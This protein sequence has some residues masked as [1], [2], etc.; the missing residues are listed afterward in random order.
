MNSGVE[1]SPSIMASLPALLASNIKTSSR[2]RDEGTPTST[3]S[4]SSPLQSPSPCAHPAT[5]ALESSPKEDGFILPPP[6]YPNPL[7][8]NTFS[9]TSNPVKIATYPKAPSPDHALASSHKESYRESGGTPT[10]P[11]ES[12]LKYGRRPGHLNSVTSPLALFPIGSNKRTDSFGAP[13][14]SVPGSPAFAPL[15]NVSESSAPQAI[16]S[17]DRRLSMVYGKHSPL[18]LA[19]NVP[20]VSSASVDFHNAS[21][22]PRETSNQLTSS[23]ALKSAQRSAVYGSEERRKSFPAQ[24][25]PGLRPKL[26]TSAT[27]TQA[28]KS[29]GNVVL[30]SSSEDERRDSKFDRQDES[31]IRGRSRGRKTSSAERSASRSRSRSRPSHL[32]LEGM[33]QQ[34]ASRSGSRAENDRQRNKSIGLRTRSRSNSSRH[35][36]SSPEDKRHASRLT[37]INDADEATLRTGHHHVGR[38]LAT[39]VGSLHI[40]GAQDDDLTTNKQVNGSDQSVSRGRNSESKATHNLKRMFEEGVPVV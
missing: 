9:A 40:D 26:T 8:S 36:R 24:F 27:E 21:A 39:I 3:S 20:R 38:D 31:S 2:P 32:G 13:R 11:S 14:P 28:Q 12:T 19:A 6:A 15:R 16:S 34:R 22:S 35:G 4:S 30:S 5:W 18:L 10:R 1:D 37:S 23:A 25:F 17:S 33:T 7:Y 29:N